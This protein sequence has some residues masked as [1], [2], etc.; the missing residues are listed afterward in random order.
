MQP[1][2][3]FWNVIVF[4]A[5]DMSGILPLSRLLGRTARRLRS[6]TIVS[7]QIQNSRGPFIVRTEPFVITNGIVH[8]CCETNSCPKQV[9]AQR[10]ASAPP[11]A[12]RPREQIG[13]G[14]QHSPSFAQVPHAAGSARHPFCVCRKA[15]GSS[16]TGDGQG[17]ARRDTRLAW[18]EALFRFRTVYCSANARIR[19]VVTFWSRT[20]ARSTYIRK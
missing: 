3:P 8:R 12:V 4:V 19:L 7:T 17:I 20:V 2:V 1:R 10:H 16:S 5:S 14:C 13:T 11:P 18:M 15:N 6:R 9:H